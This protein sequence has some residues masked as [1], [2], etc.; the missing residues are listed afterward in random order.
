[1]TSFE[2]RLFVYGTLLDPMVRSAILGKE[3]DRLLVRS[4]RLPGYRR[5]TVRN[6]TYPFLREAPN[7]EVEGD[8]L[9]RLSAAGLDLISRYEGAEYRIAECSVKTENQT[10]TAFVYL[11]KRE[12]P[13]GPDWSYEMWRRRHRTPL[14][15]RLKRSGGSG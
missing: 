12:V 1:M 13:D 3:A 7:G 4:A 11:S 8:V 2:R 14:L 15:Q 6:V 10:V 5:V 9:D